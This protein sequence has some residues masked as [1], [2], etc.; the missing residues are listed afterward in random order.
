MRVLITLGPTQEP[1]DDVRFITN[2]SSGKMGAALAEEA[3]R[4]GHEVTVVSG[5]V[6]IQL[7][8]KA[9]VHKVRTG[10]EMTQKTLGLLALTDVLISTAAI[11]DYTPEKKASGKIKS[12][13]ELVLR[14][15]PTRKLIKEARARHPELRIVG[16]K[17]EYGLNQ[18]KLV[19]SA[20]KNLLEN[21][22]DLTIANDLKKGVF[23]SDKTE[24]YVIDADTVIK[25]GRITKKKAAEII[26]DKIEE[27]DS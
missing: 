12:G 21:K 11:A 17:A 4:R 20:R 13:G 3:L 15:K 26:W 7:P 19:E 18:A 1:I 6:S 25:T 22:L 8:V 10:E 23:N 24:A 16:F 9:D 27:L 2:A 14:L 5:P